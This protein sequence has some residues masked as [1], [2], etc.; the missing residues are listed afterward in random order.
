MSTCM[1]DTEEVSNFS[2]QQASVVAY[3]DRGEIWGS[4]IRD[5]DPAQ[6]CRTSLRQRTLSRVIMTASAAIG[7]GGVLIESAGSH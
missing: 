1:T 5:R 7:D 2:V 4:S 3:G 6:S